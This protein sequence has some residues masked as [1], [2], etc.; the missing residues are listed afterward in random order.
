MRLYAVE[1][2]SYMARDFFLRSIT[3]ARLVSS[4]FLRI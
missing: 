3:A 4:W 2:A 1:R